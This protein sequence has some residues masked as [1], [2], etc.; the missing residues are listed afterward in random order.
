MR[1]RAQN[2]RTGSATMK[3]SPGTRAFIN[4]QTQFENAGDA[5]ILRELIKLVSARVPTEVYHGAAP[6]SFVDQLDLTAN[7]STST[8][9]DGALVKLVRDL[10]RA[11]L[12]GWRCYLFLTPGA[13]NGERTRKQTATDLLRIGLL[14]FLRLVGVRI[15]QVGVSFEHIGPRH[16]RLLRWRSRLLFA[17]APREPIGY[18]YAKDLGVRVTGMMP[19]LAFN[20]FSVPSGRGPGPANALAFSFRVDKDAGTRARVKQIVL[21]VVNASTPGE[22]LIFVAQV[23]RDVHFMRE[24]AEMADQARPGQVRFVDCH[25]DIE[26]AIATYSECRAVLS[27][28][29]HALLPALW[30]GAAPIALTVPELDPKISGVFT[31]IG[32]EGRVFDIRAVEYKEI[33]PL[34]SHPQFAG[35]AVASE[36]NKFFDELLE[37]VDSQAK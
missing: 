3:R 10:L 32:L 8:H 25:S 35:D 17:S 5:L 36:L 37:T 27:N 16:A 26:K 28:R 19:D 12:G 14:V 7:T 11:R 33:Q 15:C 13:P 9:A 20:L 22:Q 34:M 30:G 21:D 18:K 4:I 6:W 23:G 29:L 1:L 24:V 2:S 31:S